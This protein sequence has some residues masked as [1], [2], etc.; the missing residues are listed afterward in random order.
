[1]P[2]PKKIKAITLNPKWNINIGD[3]ANASTLLIDQ[4]YDEIN[5]HELWNKERV[6]RFCAYMKWTEYEL[7]SLIML[8]HSEMKRFMRVGFPGPV[9]LLF[10]II[11]FY[12]A[13][14]RLVDCPSQNNLIPFQKLIEFQ[15]KVRDAS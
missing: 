11:E 5:L 4:H 14:H 3:T 10:S 12:F 15:Q 9:S 8:P 2:K 13:P 6:E 7:A 1:M